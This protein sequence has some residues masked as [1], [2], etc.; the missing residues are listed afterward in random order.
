M[1]MPVLGR[2]AS[3]RWSPPASSPSDRRGG[4]RRAG[5][6]LL[7]PRRSRS[8]PAPRT[9]AAP[10]CSTGSST[11]SRTGGS[12]DEELNYRRF[13]DV[14]T[15]AG[16]RVE[17]RAGLR[18]DAR[19]AARPVAEG[20]STGCGSTTPTASPTPGLPAAG[21]RDATDGAWVVVEKILEGDEPLPTTGRCAGTTG[22]DA[23]QRIQAGADAPTGG[24]LDRAL[25]RHLRR[26]RLRWPSS[27]TP[28]SAGRR[29]RCCVP[30]WTG[31]SR[32]PSRSICHDDLAAARPHPARLREA[33]VELLVA[34]RRSTGPTCCRATPA[35]RVAVRPARRDAAAARRARLASRS[36]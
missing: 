33:L 31:W 32:S 26:R 13:F 25:A 19:R 7:R 27:S 30:R 28:P 24:P 22:Y 16:V 29:P 3:A 6:A 14:D 15:L 1:L 11:G 8:A 20:A 4:R 12:G 36:G 35:D 18:R 21:S 23:L 34:R 2:R 17:D 10:S 5:A 9:A